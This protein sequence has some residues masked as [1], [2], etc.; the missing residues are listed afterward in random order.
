MAYDVD[1]VVVGAGT[2]G[3]TAA[4]Y[5][6]AAGRRVA[7]LDR[8]WAPG[9]HAGVFVR[10]GYEFD[11][12]LHYLGSTRHGTP[13]T[14]AMLAPLGVQV[15][16]LPIDPADV[17]VLPDGERVPVPRGLEAFRDALH[18]A[19][20]K[21]REA[22]DRYLSTI[23]A[24]DQQVAELR[25][26]PSL[27]GL[28]DSLRRTGVL[29]RHA[30]S[31]VGG[32]Y[33]A[34]RLSER[35]RTLLNWV[36][37]VY[38]VPPDEASLVMHALTSLHYVNGAWYPRGG[39]AV[40]SQALADVVER[41]G[42]QFL[43]Q[44]EVERILVSGGRV[45]GVRARD[46]AGGVVEVSAPVVIAAGD[47]KRTFLELLDPA[48]VPVSLR[49]RVRGYEMALP[50]AVGY[51]VV[52]R[53]LVAEGLAASNL[54]IVPEGDPQR[55]YDSVRRGVLPDRPATWLTCASLKDPDNP[56]LCPP[57]QTNLQLMCVAPPQ[58]RAW[59][60][61][62]G[63]AKGAA[64]QS[65]KQTLLQTLLNSADRGIPGLSDAVIYADLATPYTDSRYTGVTDGTSY[66]IAA[67]PGQMAW[68]RPGPK[69]H[70]PGLFLAGASTRSHHG[71]TGTMAS[72]ID[73]ATAV[74]GRSATATVAG[75]SA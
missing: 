46:G 30:R 59:G 58:P 36:S 40:I 60:L 28:P 41:R 7:V 73:A 57:G 54:V 20:P 17:V 68:R 75:S 43:L 24:I 32:F 63:E 29:V 61:E 2:G 9:G 64:Y 62:L 55:S 19:L 14:R 39:G 53:D 15:D 38:A 13:A 33:D 45:S 67:T 4:A 70:L 44:H 42:G 72:G 8:G 74:L 25:R 16:Y 34:L 27:S 37:G 21:E 47:V 56:R 71:I 5:L 35:A 31:T 6:A 66:G 3:L 11:I 1:V 18:Q 65:A 69:T 26:R 49:R 22:V 48:V 23:D 50:L 10:E 12:G 52:Q 51:V